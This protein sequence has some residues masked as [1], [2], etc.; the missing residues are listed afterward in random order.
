MKKH[1]LFLWNNYLLIIILII[2]YAG[3]T[4][5]SFLS[6][7]NPNFLYLENFSWIEAVSIMIFFTTLILAAKS[8]KWFTILMV[9]NIL[10]LPAS[11][12]NIF[13]SILISSP[14]DIKEVYFPMIT[15]IDIFLIFGLFRYWDNISAR[16]LVFKATGRKIVYIFI[17]FLT[18]S[19]VINVFENNSLLDVG[20]ILSHSYHLRYLLLLLLLF[21]NTP[22]IKYP[23]EIFIGILISILFLIFESFFF[24]YVFAYKNRLASGT[25]GNNVFANVLTAI[26]C[27]YIYLI[28][29]KIISKK[30]LVLVF[31]MTIVII[32]TT[33]RSALFLL[34]LY[35]LSEI[36]IHIIY[37]F[38]QKSKRKGILFACLFSIF[39]ITAIFSL[40]QNER[41]SFNNFK[42]EKFDFTKQNLR[43]MIVLKEN[44]FNASL[45]LRLNHFQT[46][47]NMIKDKPI[48]GIGPG[49]WN[50]YKADYG[51][52][53][54]HVLDS[55]NTFLALAS[56]YGLIT[57]GLFIFNIYLFPFILYRKKQLKKSQN[58]LNYLFIISII[59]MFTGITNAEV[60]KHQIFG[61]LILILMYFIFTKKE[62]NSKNNI[63][64]LN[65]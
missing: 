55:H 25:L 6:I 39:L 15:H 4:V 1:N 63:R 10:A 34:L 16:F 17:F 23:K 27:Y 45:I 48:F 41:L 29:R 32:L 56:Q 58:S 54:T 42:I 5:I 20:L 65:G 12:D 19:I 36:V 8:F 47:L 38:K 9:F 57:A 46:S 26:L 62:C 18:L 37:Q 52:K 31:V 28:I 59:T 40:S 7:K 13:P 43:D 33:T 30:Y 61:F 51:S 49:R 50:R 3:I 35:L 21:I 11:I 24:T 53:D 44:K 22:I 64:T 60:F 2:I 14:I